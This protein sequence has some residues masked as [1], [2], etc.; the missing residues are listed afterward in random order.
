VDPLCHPCWAAT[1]HGCLLPNIVTALSAAYRL[2]DYFPVV[3][4]P[5]LLPESTV[6]QLNGNIQPDRDYEYT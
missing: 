5:A 4:L 2:V 1:A 6:G 3:W